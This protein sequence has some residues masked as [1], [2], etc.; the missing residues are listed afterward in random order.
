MNKIKKILGPIQVRNL[1]KSLL[2]QFE[3]LLTDEDMKRIEISKKYKWKIIE[4]RI[5]KALIEFKKNPKYELIIEICRKSLK[6]ID[7]GNGETHR[8]DLDSYQ[9]EIYEIAKKHK[10]L[11]QNSNQT[12]IFFL[13]QLGIRDDLFMEGYNFLEKN[14]N[15]KIQNQDSTKYP[16]EMLFK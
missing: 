12:N 8:L 3:Y 11:I 16:I 10:L 9:N 7:D 2:I 6:L 4:E 1:A 5:E 14:F 13:S 15:D